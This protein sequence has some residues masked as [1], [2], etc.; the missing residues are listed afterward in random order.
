MPTDDPNPGSK[1]ASD[2]ADE[3]TCA[4]GMVVSKEHQRPRPIS[5]DE[6]RQR[7]GDNGDFWAVVDGFV[8]DATEFIDRHP[9]GL[10]K[11]LSANSASAGATGHSF[12]F[13]FSRGRNAHFPDTG[14]RFQNG[15]RKYLDGASSHGDEFLPS[16]KVPF[17]DFGSLTIL[18]KLRD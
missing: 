1:I 7:N 6:V 17:Q 13:S 4:E 3:R 8:V 10:R 2:H 18:G 9:G 15:V 16:V 14:Q 12:G 5:A 11:L